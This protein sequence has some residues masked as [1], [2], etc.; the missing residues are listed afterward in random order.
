M[1]YLKVVSTEKTQFWVQIYK[2]NRWKDCW[3][4][5]TLEESQESIERMNRAYPDAEYRIVK[6]Q[7]IEEIC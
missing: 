3:K 5:E 2:D 4:H 6:R 7:I 1:T